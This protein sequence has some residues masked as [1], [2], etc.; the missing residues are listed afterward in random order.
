MYD[1]Y[2]ILTCN[3]L[4]IS[5]CIYLVYDLLLL[6]PLTTYR[7]PSVCGGAYF[8]KPVARAVRRILILIYSIKF[9]PFFAIFRRFPIN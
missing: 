1:I 8:C 4:S 6:S 7:P 3:D 9:V 2:Y 5:I